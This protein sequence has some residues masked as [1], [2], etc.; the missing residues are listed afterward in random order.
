MVR[1]LLSNAGFMQRLLMSPRFKVNEK[2]CHYKKP[3]ILLG[4]DIRKNKSG[5]LYLLI[6][7]KT[8]VFIFLYHVRVW[9]WLHKPKWQPCPQPDI[10]MPSLPLLLFYN[11]LVWM[12]CDKYLIKKKKLNLFNVNVL[13]VRVLYFLCNGCEWPKMKEGWT[14]QV[15]FR[16]VYLQLKCSDISLGCK[17]ELSPCIQHNP[18]S[19][20]G[21]W[22]K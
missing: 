3:W 13:P 15:R 20:S 10:N 12:L 4:T 5:N 9:I 14:L 22:L 17:Q 2:Y 18:E 1:V 19:L 11:M 7:S 21:H 16:A 8:F 6:N